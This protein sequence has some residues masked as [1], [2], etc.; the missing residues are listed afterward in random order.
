MLP[1]QTMQSQVGSVNNTFGIKGVDQYCFYF[2]SIE[3]ANR[4]VWV[5]CVGYRGWG[6]K[7]GG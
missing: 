3:D 6:G 5:V 4:C 2:K 1:Y 7:G